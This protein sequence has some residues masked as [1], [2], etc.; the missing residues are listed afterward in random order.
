M[1]EP[2]ITVEK[3]ENEFF[4]IWYNNGSGTSASLAENIGNK[5]RAEI[6]AAVLDASTIESEG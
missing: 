6:M 4:T 2:N 1:S 3:Q 5:K